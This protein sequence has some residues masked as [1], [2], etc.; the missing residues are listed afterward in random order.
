M[1]R[2][3]RS[4]VKEP[5]KSIYCRFSA[6]LSSCFHIHIHIH[7]HIRSGA[8]KNSCEEQSGKFFYHCLETIKG[9]GNVQT[10]IKKFAGNLLKFN[11]KLAPSP[12][13]GRFTSFSHS[14][15]SQKKLMR[16]AIQEILLPFFFALDT[17]LYILYCI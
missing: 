5:N 3:R 8:P 6:R 17:Q 7:F 10:F 12:L 11:V 13:F 4:R 15:G 1:R 2:G 16:R 9:Y 14:I